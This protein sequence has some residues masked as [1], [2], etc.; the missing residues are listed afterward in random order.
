[1]EQQA[2]D[3][4]V[5]RMKKRR[6]ANE[7]EEAFTRTQRVDSLQTVSSG[8][9]KVRSLGFLFIMGASTSSIRRS[10]GSG[11]PS[12]RHI[13]SIDRD[14]DN[15]GS[16][17]RNTNTPAQ[18]PLHKEEEILEEIHHLLC[19]EEEFSSQD[20]ELY[21]FIRMHLGLEECWTATTLKNYVIT[22]LAPRLYKFPFP[23]KMITDIST[24]LNIKYS[25]ELELGI[26][27][28][29]NVGVHLK[30]DRTFHGLSF[31]PEC[32]PAPTHQH[33]CAPRSGGSRRE[34]NGREREESMNLE[35]P[36]EA[37]RNDSEISNL[38]T[39]PSIPR[40]IRRRSQTS[41][42]SES[43]ERPP[44]STQRTRFDPTQQ[45]LAVRFVYRQYKEFGRGIRVNN[46]E[47]WRKFIRHELNSSEDKSPQAWR[48]QYVFLNLL[49]L[50]FEVIEIQLSSGAE[51]SDLQDAIRSIQKARAVVIP[52]NGYQSSS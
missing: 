50:S 26:E 39:S 4:T 12:N 13:S 25:K 8:Y 34:D 44:T 6:R 9:D 31:W 37:R 38:F 43:P 19:V 32:A 1:M 2:L 30:D 21:E 23:L 27:R 51:T 49:G 42:E 5:E 47:F 18:L 41:N 17:V 24:A 46:N 35:V 22:K 36:R 7:A 45:R 14:A 40:R 28:R 11:S 3:N 20:V 10:L 29:F 16:I 33:Q 15:I 52:G 48:T